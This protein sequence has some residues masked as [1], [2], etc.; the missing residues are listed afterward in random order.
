MYGKVHSQLEALGPI[1]FILKEAVKGQLNQKL[2]IEVAQTALRFLGNASVN[3]S[4]ERRK[5][6]L[7]NMNTRLLDMA[8]DDAIYKSAAPSLFGDG[9]CK[10]TKERDEELK[11]LW[12][13]GKVVEPPVTLS[14]FEAAVPIS[15]SPVGKARPSEDAE[16]ATKGSTPV[17]EL[18]RARTSG[19]TADRS[20]KR[21]Q[22]ISDTTSSRA[23]YC[24]FKNR[25]SL[26]SY[27]FSSNQ[28]PYSYGCDKYDSKSCQN[29]MPH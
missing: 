1:T 3:A 21:L 16:G 15:N 27:V 7:Q 25:L 13:L 8:E 6:A 12:L 20:T 2:A 29:P 4:S 14:F 22:T 17:T 9:F 10:N 24:T 26:E 18:Q 11:C 23:S 28:H 19:P 5:S